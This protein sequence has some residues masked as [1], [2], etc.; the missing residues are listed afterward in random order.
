VLEI[1]EGKSE[2]DEGAENLF[3]VNMEAEHK[4]GHGDA[5]LAENEVPRAWHSQKL[6]TGGDAGCQSEG[7]SELN[8]HSLFEENMNFHEVVQYAPKRGNFI[9]KET[10]SHREDSGN[11]TFDTDSSFKTVFDPG[12]PQNPESDGKNCE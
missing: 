9:F 10:T 4:E 7:R 12:S 3:F 1:I 2:E 6:E 5:K 11:Y 8:L